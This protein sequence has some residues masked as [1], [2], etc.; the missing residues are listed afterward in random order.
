[1]GKF[2]RVIWGK[3]LR[4]NGALQRRLRYCHGSHWVARVQRVQKVQRVQ[5]GWYRQ[6]IRPSGVRVQKV[7]RVLPAYSGRVQRGRYRLTAMSFI[8]SLREMKTKQPHPWRERKT[9]QPGFARWKCTPIPA[10]GGTS[11]K[12]KHVTEFSGR[13][14]S[15]QIQFLCHPGGGGA[16]GGRGAF[17]APARAVV[18]FLPAHQLTS[19]LAHYTDFIQTGSAA[20]HH[21]L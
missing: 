13:C 8:I 17:P 19:T 3:V 5:R 2:S 15:L 21:P 16:V 14:A 9:G 4:F 18:W 1:M 10:C 20:A 6:R 7:Q 12:G 11:P